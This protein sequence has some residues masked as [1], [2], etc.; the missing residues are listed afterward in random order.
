MYFS[1]FALTTHL[2]W[3]LFIFIY[4]AIKALDTKKGKWIWVN[5]FSS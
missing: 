4:I 1:E 5:K 2:V 3:E